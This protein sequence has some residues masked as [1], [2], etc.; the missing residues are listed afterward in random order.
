MNEVVS[1]I[2]WVLTYLTCGNETFST[3]LLK[4]GLALLLVSF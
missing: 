2:C 4:E 1:E 3:E